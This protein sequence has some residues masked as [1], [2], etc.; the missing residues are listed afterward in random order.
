MSSHSSYRATWLYLPAL[1][2][3]R[4]VISVGAPRVPG[5]V[6]DPSGIGNDD[7]DA[8]K[9]VSKYG[10]PVRGM[11]RLPQPLSS[12]AMK[13]RYG[14]SPPQG[15]MYAPENLGKGKPIDSME[16]L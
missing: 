6:N 14:L 5:Q 16:I 2:F 7:F 12:S 4:H 10:Y 1:R 8:G 11:Y 3:Y 13:Q 9:K 15:Y